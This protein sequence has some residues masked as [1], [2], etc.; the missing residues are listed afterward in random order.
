MKNEAGQS[1][2]ADVTASGTHGKPLIRAAR[3]SEIVSMSALFEDE[4][5]AGRMLPRDPA[6]VAAHIDNWLVAEENGRIVGCVSLVFFNQELCEVRSLAVH[7]N[8]RGNGL[9]GDLIRAAVDMARTRGMRRVLTLTRSLGVFE[10][11]GFTRDLIV[12]FPEKVWRDC[13]P[14]PFRERCD[15]VTLIYHLDAPGSGNGHRN[16]QSGGHTPP[17]E[18]D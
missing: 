2:E 3:V 9:G 15:E 10:R 13:T 6:E 1:E 7:S 8:H 5:R 14:C 11:V 4:V 18:L 16:G 12:N 17:A